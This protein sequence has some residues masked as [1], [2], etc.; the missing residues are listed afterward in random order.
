LTFRA[1]AFNI[2]NHT[3]YGNPGVN[4]VG[5]AGAFGQIGGTYLQSGNANRVMQLS[6]RLE[7]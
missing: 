5:N 1:D 6:L 4:I 3:S 2:L 7:F